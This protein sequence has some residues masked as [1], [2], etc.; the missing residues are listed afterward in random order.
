M[1]KR[2]AAAGNRVPTARRTSADRAG[3]N[4]RPAAKL[5]NAA[6]IHLPGRRPN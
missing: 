2:R 4:T 3:V 5:S 6:E 1:K